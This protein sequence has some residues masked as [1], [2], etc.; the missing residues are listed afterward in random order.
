MNDLP[1]HTLLHH[2][3]VSVSD[4]FSDLVLL[5]DGGGRDG[6]VSIH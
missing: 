4:H 2:S 5:V 1:L 6:P 3:K